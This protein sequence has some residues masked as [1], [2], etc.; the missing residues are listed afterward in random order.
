ARVVGGLA[1]TVAQTGISALIAPG[2]PP[3]PLQAP[4][5]PSNRKPLAGAA[6]RETEVPS[7]NEAAQT[8]P[9]SMPAGVDW[10]AP[11]P[12]TPMRSPNCWMGRPPPIPPSVSGPASIEAPPVDTLQEAP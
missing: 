9:Q 1:R 8:W 2:H 10:M 5:H 6:V 3:G 11:W 7:S 4:P 12:F